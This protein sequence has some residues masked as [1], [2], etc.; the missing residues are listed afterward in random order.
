MVHGL[1]LNIL[2][3]EVEPVFPSVIAYGLITGNFVITV[4]L[5]FMVIS[6]TSHNQVLKKLLGMK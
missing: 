2:M 5:S 6:L 3:P 4:I 1:L